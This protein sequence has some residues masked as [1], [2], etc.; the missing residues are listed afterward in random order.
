ME[1]HYSFD[2]LSEDDKRKWLEI[3]HT[4][5][6]EER[7]FF[8][9]FIKI[10]GQLWESERKLLYKTIRAFKPLNV[11]EVGTWFGGGS[12]FFISQ[13]LFEN[14]AGVI[15]TVENDKA[16][17]ESAISSYKEYLGYLLPHVKFI[18][19]NSHEVF[20][21]IMKSEGRVEALFLDGSDDPERAVK[22]YNLFAPYLSNNALLMA[23]DWTNQKMIYF[24]PMIESMP[25]W[26][27]IEKVDPPYSVGTVVYKRCL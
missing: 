19:G 2:A 9:G 14:G 15:Y 24:R 6:Y 16:F 3:R 10:R 27:L 12:T 18:H 4:I 13:A 21:P 20:P 1:L 5:P 11:F 23:H 25:E 22:E 17:H 7:W 8:E 26:K